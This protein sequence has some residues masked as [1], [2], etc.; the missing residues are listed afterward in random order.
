MKIFVTGGT[1]FL[2]SHFLQQAISAG[3]EL[4]ALRRPG[5]KTRIALDVEPRWV[6]GSLDEVPEAILADCDTLVH[7][8]AHGVTNPT[9]AS[10]EECFRW[11]VTSSLSLWLKAERTG[12][13]RYIIC[14]SCFEYGKSGECF[15]FIPTDAPLIPTSAYDASKASAT[16]AALAFSIDKNRE[17]VVLRPFHVYGEGESENRFWPSLRRAALAGENFPMTEGRQ[18]RDFIPVE[19]VASAFVTALTRQDLLQGVPRVEN[20]GT[21]NPR[22]LLQFAEAEWKRWNAAG[23]LLPGVL[24]QRRGEVMRYVPEI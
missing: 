12:I 14:G 23:K 11:N 9:N 8:A 2:G 5:S 13:R 1:G 3:H 18:I 17:V 20:I 15:D 24:P 10:W 6:E 7:F 22:S 16:A 4:V 21:G 19:Q